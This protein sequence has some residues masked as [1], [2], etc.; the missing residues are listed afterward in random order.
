MRS[1]KQEDDVKIFE[2]VFKRN[3]GL[4]LCLV[5]GLVLIMGIPAL[6]I[7]AISFER[8]NRSDQV[9]AEVSQRYGGHQF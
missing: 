3:Y 8:S 7:S 2:K 1:F 4:K 9:T 5:C 6:M